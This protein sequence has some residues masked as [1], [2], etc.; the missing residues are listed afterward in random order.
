MTPRVF[1]SY[2]LNISTLGKI[3]IGTGQDLDPTQYVIDEDDLLHEFSLDT[4]VE[5]FSQ[6]D[7]NELLQHVSNIRSAGMVRKVQN[8]IRDRSRKLIPHAHRRIRVSS[9]IAKLYRGR[10]Q[11]QSQHQNAL[12]IQR[13]YRNPATGVPILPG[14]SLKGAIRT[15]LLNQRKRNQPNPVS[16]NERRP[17]DLEMTLFQYQDFHQDPMRLIHV[18]DTEV[19]DPTQPPHA[20]VVF[21]VNRKKKAVMNRGQEVLS[22][23]EKG[24]LYQ[25]LEVVSDRQMQAFHSRL[26]LHQP[27]VLSSAQHHIPAQRFTAQDIARA[28]K[29]FYLPLLAQELELLGERGFAYADWLSWARK[30]YVLVDQ[31]KNENLFPLRVG[32]HS[33]AEAVT[34]EGVRNIRIMQ[35]KEQKPRVAE[36]SETL[37]LAANESAARSKMIPF[38]WIVI[39]LTDGIV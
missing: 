20:S 22:M 10:T 12:E 6:Q 11:P 19:M 28:C 13:M 23:A 14:S 17:K 24:N 18:G 8:L 27:D 31:N 2:Q 35:G 15:A 33:G 30:I 3:H 5:A 39:G 32:H 26:V 1:T 37:W 34:I 16:A 29:D 4:L 7:R 21:A 25:M 36:A 38:G 9:G